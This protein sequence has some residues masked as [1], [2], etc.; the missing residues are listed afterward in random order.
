MAAIED[1]L[2]E[3]DPTRS[4]IDAIVEFQ[5]IIDNIKPGDKK[6]LGEKFV[7]WKT[8]CLYYFLTHSKNSAGLT[9]AAPIIIKRFKECEAEALKKSKKNLNKFLYASTRCTAYLTA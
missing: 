3:F 9:S 5:N 1:K 4:D 7:I 2:L 6:A 8:G